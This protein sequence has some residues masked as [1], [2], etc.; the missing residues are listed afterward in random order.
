MAWQSSYD[1]GPGELF[2]G[3]RMT[4]GVKNLLIATFVAFLLQQWMTA[5]VIGTLSLSRLM[6]DNLFLWQPVTYMFL[7]ADFGHILM[8]MLGLFFLGPETERALGTRRFL[9]LYFFAGAIAGLIWLLIGRLAWLFFGQ[10]EGFCI[11]AS[12]AVLGIVGAFGTL[13]PNRRIT[14]L[15]FFVLPVT[16]TG[17]TL[18]LSYAVLSLYIMLMPSSGQI[19]HSVHLIGLIVGFLY[20]RRF[21]RA[22]PSSSGAPGIIDDLLARLRRRRMRVVPREE[23]SLPSANDVDQVLEK[24]A[25]SGMR[26]LTR[27]ERKIL[28]RASND[29]DVDTD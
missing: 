5:P 11:G 7:H 10:V 13:F 18:A 21:M 24:I 12:G 23:N 26:S 16:I 1:R 20:C 17:R 3:F 25:R 4:P 29:E 22:E 14:L 28:D 2:G 8:N 15:L 27:E 9:R 19:A 6:T